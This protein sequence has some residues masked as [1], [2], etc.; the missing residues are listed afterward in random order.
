MLEAA[1][2]SRLQLTTLAAK[3][4]QTGTGHTWNGVGFSLTIGL[5]WRQREPFSA[6]KVLDWKRTSGKMLGIVQFIRVHFIAFR[7]VSD[8]VHKS[9]VGIL[10]VG[11]VDLGSALYARGDGGDRGEVLVALERLAMWTLCCCIP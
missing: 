6:R 8:M 9:W 11:D 5:A 7:I 3:Q 4:S 10:I 1:Q 2:R